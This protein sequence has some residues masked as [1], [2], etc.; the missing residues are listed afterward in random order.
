MSML[1]KERN[2]DIFRRKKCRCFQ[3]K[4]MSMLLKERNVDAFRKKKCRCF[5]KERIS[6]FSKE[7]NVDAFKRKKC[8]CIQ[9]KEM[10]MFSKERNI[11]AFRRKE[12]RCFQKK[13]ISIYSSKYSSR[14]FLFIKRIFKTS[15]LTIM[16]LK[17]KIYVSNTCYLSAE[18]FEKFIKVFYEKKIEYKFKKEISMLLKEVL[19]RLNNF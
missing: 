6:M 1:S 14:F 18:N 3:K 5:Q 13:G 7:R 9:K 8:R 2:V 4:E 17:K 11:D 15:F 19:I 10:S 16:H 12:Y